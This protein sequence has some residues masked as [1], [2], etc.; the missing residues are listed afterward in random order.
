MKR[1]GQDGSR[2]EEPPGEF[3]PS[4][5]LPHL[6]KCP[7]RPVERSDCS[8]IAQSCSEPVVHLA[9][10]PG[11]DSQSCGSPAPPASARIHGDVPE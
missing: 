1:K 6:L 9:W 8:K 4:S 10:N 5:F 2:C 11:C 7:V 3:S